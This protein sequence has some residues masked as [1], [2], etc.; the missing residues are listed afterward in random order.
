MD[1]DLQVGNQGDTSVVRVFGE[2]D[3]Y[4]APRLDECLQSLISSGTNRIAVDL[5]NC[6]YIDS[7]G[8]K[9]LIKAVRERDGQPSLAICGARGIVLRILEITGLQALFELL[10][11]IRDLPA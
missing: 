6:A 4:T 8:I 1:F 10:P 9:V 2:V 5:E 3:V 7:E 11:S